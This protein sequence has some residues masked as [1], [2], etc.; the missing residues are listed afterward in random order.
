MS[1]SCGQAMH[2]FD[3]R[4]PARSVNSF[5][6]SGL[7]IRN[8]FFISSHLFLHKNF[9]EPTSQL[10]R[11]TWSALLISYI[12]YTAAAQSAAGFRSPD[13]FRRYTPL[14]LAWGVSKPLHTYVKLA[15][16]YLHINGG[17]GGAALGLAGVLE[18]RYC[19]LRLGYHQRVSQLLW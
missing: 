16:L 11:L 10:P 9:L 7:H 1:L 14:P 4:N 19:E 8:Y 17:S 18:G 5:T 3:M 12:I 15:A 6:R 13:S 2:C